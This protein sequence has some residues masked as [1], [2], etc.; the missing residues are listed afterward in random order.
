MFVAVC[1]LTLTCVSAPHH[2][3]QYG[4]NCLHL[5]ARSGF[6]DVVQWLLD[7]DPPLGDTNKVRMPN[8]PCI[9][10]T[11]LLTPQSRENALSLAIQHCHLDT[12]ELLLDK[13]APLPEVRC[14]STTYPH[15]S[16]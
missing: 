16:V 9:H 11:H 3:L 13:N 7:N 8:S 10:V 14:A 2:F 4:N 12:T 6:L 5:A 1:V 15:L